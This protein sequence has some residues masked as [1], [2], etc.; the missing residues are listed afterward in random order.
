[1]DAESRAR[2]LDEAIEAHHSEIVETIAEAESAADEETARQKQSEFVRIIMD[3]CQEHSGLG[4]KDFTMEELKGAVGR[5]IVAH[6]ARADQ[7][8]AEAQ[9]LERLSS[10]VSRAN[11]RTEGLNMEEIIGRLWREGALS[12]DEYRWAQSLLQRPMRE[13]I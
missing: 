4:P 2:L 1:M 6:A 13:E 10:L 11:F 12:E 3:Y 9:D 8:S 5:Q 7:N